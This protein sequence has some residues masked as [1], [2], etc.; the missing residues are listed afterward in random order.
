MGRKQVDCVEV[1]D[2][3][4]P[5]EIKPLC[6]RLEDKVLILRPRK[7]DRRY[8]N[9]ENMLWEAHGGFGCNPELM[10]RAIVATCL[11]DGETVRWNREDFAGIYAGAPI[12]KAPEKEPGRYKD[13]PLCEVLKATLRH[14]P[15][16]GEEEHDLRERIEDIISKESRR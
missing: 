9:R 2:F 15:N 14:I 13:S 11:A 12:A 3:F 10:G 16:D 4:S 8:Q 7:L 6:G 1:S 5:E